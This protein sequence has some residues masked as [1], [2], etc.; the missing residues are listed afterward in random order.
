MLSATQQPFNTRKATVFCAALTLLVLTVPF[1]AQQFTAEVNWKVFDFM[2]MGAMVFSFS[3]SAAYLS[4][5]KPMMTRILTCVAT[6][7]FFLL[8]WAELAVG[9]F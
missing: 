4:A 6:M 5:K 7:A 3:L 2:V 8:L 9:I 1:I